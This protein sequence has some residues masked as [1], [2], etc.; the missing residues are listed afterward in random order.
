MHQS[1]FLLPR[2]NLARFGAQAVKDTRERN[3]GIGS[4]I[5]SKSPDVGVLDPKIK[6]SLRAER[7]HELRKTIRK[8]CQ[9]SRDAHNTYQQVAF[10]LRCGSFGAER[11]CFGK[12]GY[13]LGNA[14]KYLKRD[15]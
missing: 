9:V 3:S 13:Q 14:A 6:L 5:L 12:A 11:P 2:F 1:L 4:K 7:T 15:P 8:K 10:E